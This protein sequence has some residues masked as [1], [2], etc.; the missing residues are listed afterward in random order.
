MAR[1]AA[2]P[3]LGALVDAIM[4]KYPLTLGGAVGGASKVLPID[5]ISTGLLRLDWELGCGGIPRYRCTEVWGPD[6]A[7][8]TTLMGTMA[9]RLSVTP[10]ADGRLYGTT[11]ILD[12]ENKLKEP[13]LHECVINSGGNLGTK[14]EP[15]IIHLQPPSGEAALQIAINSVGKVDLIVFDSV[16]W[17]TP[18]KI[19]KK[20]AGVEDNFWALQARILGPYLQ[21]LSNLL[22]KSGR[23]KTLP[24]GTAFVGISQARSEMHEFRVKYRDGL[25]P[26]GA[27]AWKHLRSVQIY[28]HPF[29]WGLSEPVLDSQKNT[30]GAMTYITVEKNVVDNPQQHLGKPPPIIRFGMGFD[31]AD[32]AMVMGLKM[33]ILEYVKKEG[34]TGKSFYWIKSG[35][36]IAQGEQRTREYLNDVNPQARDELRAEISRRIQERAKSGAAFQALA[37]FVKWNTH[38]AGE[39]AAYTVDEKRVA[40]WQQEHS[41]EG[42]AVIIDAPGA[43]DGQVVERGA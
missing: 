16:T 9:A 5:P 22:L 1:K 36:K 38:R 17:F 12:V 28:M 34:D 11:L 33:G 27:R 39:R 4:K 26:G 41:V 7:G 43:I 2:Q 29:G 21:R 6:Q 18:S 32:D 13:Y 3:D 35:E 23:D 30:Y 8:K 40:F 42:D 24:I 19:E 14:E 25:K 31:L 37:K 10:Q 20:G 15:R